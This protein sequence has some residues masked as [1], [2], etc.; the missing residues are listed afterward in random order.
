MNEIVKTLLV[1]AGSSA[2]VALVIQHFIK[3]GIKSF[4]DKRL[5]KFKDE[6]AIYAEQRKLDFDRKL[7]DF[8]LYSSK[9]HELYPQLFKRVYELNY[10][11]RFAHDRAFLSSRFIHSL[12]DIEPYF[13]GLKISL[14][15]DLKNYI[16]NKQNEW[17]EDK[18]LCL[19]TIS[20]VIR[21]ALYYKAG[22]DLKELDEFFMGNILFFSDSVV[23]KTQKVVEEFVTFSLLIRHPDGGRETLNADIVGLERIL[24]REMKM[25]DYNI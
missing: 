6:I 21:D 11:M 20:S 19:K 8:S 5:E 2:L 7:H 15:E 14:D 9:R 1:S 17:E 12:E 16:E 18:D 23:E 25:G 22:Q 10:S 3:G 4:Y 24:K 13:K